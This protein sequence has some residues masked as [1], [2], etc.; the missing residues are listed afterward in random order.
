MKLPPPDNK[1]LDKRCRVLY[2][3]RRDQWEVYQAETGIAV[4]FTGTAGECEAFA[5]SQ[6]LK[7]SNRLQ[8][9]AEQAIV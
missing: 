2:N 5:D 6:G 7:I 1:P 8:F 3:K 9:L 4:C